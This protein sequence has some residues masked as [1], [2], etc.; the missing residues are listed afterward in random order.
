[1]NPPRSLVRS[2]LMLYVTL[3]LVV[4]VESSVTVMRLVAAPSTA[5]TACMH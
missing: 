4:L 3:G 2:F 1:V 5:P